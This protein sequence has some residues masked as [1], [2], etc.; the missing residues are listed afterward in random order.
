MRP[1]CPLR[2]YGRL[3]EEA[4][5]LEAARNTKAKRRKLVIIV[6]TLCALIIAAALVSVTV[7]IL[8]VGSKRRT[9]SGPDSNGAAN[10]AGGWKSKA[11]DTGRPH[12]TLRRGDGHATG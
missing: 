3:S 11:I 1:A 9:R 7:G 12:H 6:F 5:A 2:G 4:R 10:A 8:V